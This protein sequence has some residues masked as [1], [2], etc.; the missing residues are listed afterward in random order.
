M[1]VNSAPGLK[2]FPKAR[3][4][5]QVLG[6]ASVVTVL[7]AAVAVAASV[8]SE[9][10][11]LSQVEQ[12]SATSATYL[13][14]LARFLPFGYA[15]GAGMVSAVNPCGFALLPA[16]LGLYLRDDLDAPAAR[17]LAR[18]AMVGL[19][20]TVVF[21]VLFGLTGLAL[22][23]VG[24][25]LGSYLRWAGLAVGVLLVGGGGA[26]IAGRHLYFGLGQQLGDRAG[27]AAQARGMRAYAA[28]GLAYALG[29]LGCTLPIFLAVVGIGLVSGG[30]AGAAFQ[31][32]L[33]GLG[34]GTI[35]TTLALAAALLKQTALPKIR[36]WGGLVEPL[37]AALLLVTGGYVV[38]YWLSPGG[39][40]AAIG[41][42]RGG[43]A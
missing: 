19:T 26:V 27:D 42:G 29:S 32:A 21:V 8:Q 25:A 34:M 23:L 18:A 36:H 30:P 2:A 3:H 31:L 22:T 28:Y 16:Y 20:V 4:L 33:Y 38:F 5:R 7:V 41:A 17:R 12:L 15:F 35:L 9:S 43:G 39:V 11:G 14:R 13:S 24:T 1:T 10:G 6:L 40:L 37:S